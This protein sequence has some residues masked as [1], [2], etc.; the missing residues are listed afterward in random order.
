[1][2]DP[3][4]HDQRGSDESSPKMD[5]GGTSGRAH[6]SADPLVLLDECL[7]SLPEDDPRQKL[8]YTIRH[9]V[10]QATT[11]AQQREAEYTKLQAV[12]G[13]LTAPANRIGT[14]V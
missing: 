8:L 3:I 12:V 1:M 14:F 7:A 9:H 13:K 5:L 10:L 11:S 2:G 6:S 4:G